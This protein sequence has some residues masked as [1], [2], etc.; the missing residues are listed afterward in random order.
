MIPHNLP[1][2]PTV[3]FY[4]RRWQRM[5]IWQKINNHNQALRSQETINK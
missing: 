1:P 2:Y 5:G 3:Y 4:F